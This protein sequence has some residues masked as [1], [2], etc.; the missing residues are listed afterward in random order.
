[1]LKFVEDHSIPGE[2][3]VTRAI[4]GLH[5]PLASKGSY[6]S[7][8]VKFNRDKLEH[9]VYIISDF[10]DSCHDTRHQQ[11]VHKSGLIVG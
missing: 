4:H 2:R 10:R 11:V 1:V 8:K 6:L 9:G 3:L 7:H 5:T